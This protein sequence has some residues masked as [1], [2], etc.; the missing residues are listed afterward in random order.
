MDK[1]YIDE[2]GNRT[3]SYSENGAVSFPIG[4]I[5]GVGKTGARVR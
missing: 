1:P 3:A 4:G 5:S 2:N